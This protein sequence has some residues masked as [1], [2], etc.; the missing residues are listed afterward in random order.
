MRLAIPGIH[1]VL[2]RDKA[3]STRQVT[4]RLPLAHSSLLL[5]PPDSADNSDRRRFVARAV[6]EFYR[7]EFDIVM[8]GYVLLLW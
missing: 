2:S 1:G 7:G 3:L 5:M 8:I 6:P 4:T